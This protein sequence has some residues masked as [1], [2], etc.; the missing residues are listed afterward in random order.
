QITTA[1]AADAVHQ[2]GK[3]Y[4][5]AHASRQLR[6]T[7]RLGAA[8]AGGS[9]ISTIQRYRSA[10]QPSPS[11]S[12]LAGAASSGR[13]VCVRTPA[14]VTTDTSTTSV[15]RGTYHANAVRL[16]TSV[17]SGPRTYGSR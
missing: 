14:K 12:P 9:S 16:M 3:S 11:R 15:P 2:P 4:A 1:P 10:V 7:C 8:F 13:A 5:I 6:L 17:S